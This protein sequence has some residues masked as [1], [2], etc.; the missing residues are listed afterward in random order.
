MIE[1]LSS[2]QETTQRRSIA[3][4]SSD[5]GYSQLK[6]RSDELLSS[7]TKPLMNNCM[8]ELNH[9]SSFYS[10]VL[11]LRGGEFQPSYLISQQSA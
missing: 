7:H 1:M 11:R 10:V 5:A 9:K 2:S 3:N 4:L 8:S 6:I